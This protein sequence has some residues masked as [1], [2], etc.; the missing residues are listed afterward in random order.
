[1]TTRPTAPVFAGLLFPPQ[2]ITAAV[3]WY[4]RYGLSYWDVEESL[5]D[6]SVTV[7]HVTIYRRVRRFTPEFIEAARPRRHAPGDRWFADET[8]L[9][10]QRP[11]GIGEEPAE[12]DIRQAAIPLPVLRASP[13]R[14]DLAAGRHRECQQS[15]NV[16]SLWCGPAQVSAVLHVGPSV[17]PGPRSRADLD[18]RC[19]SAF[20]G[21][22]RQVWG[23]RPGLGPLPAGIG[24]GNTVILRYPASSC[25]SYRL[26][27]GGACAGPEPARLHLR[28]ARQQWLARQ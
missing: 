25:L 19:G 27:T 28:R 20:R 8:I 18:H 7:D 11:P 3:R 6:R 23:Q 12:P 26:L 17:R 2:V 4:L 24:G 14:D 22:Q 21:C 15:R 10:V 16:I 9:P 1:M 13:T 5:A